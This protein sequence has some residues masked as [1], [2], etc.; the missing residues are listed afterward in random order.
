MQVI[1][2]GTTGVLGFETLQVLDRVTGLDAIG[3][4]RRGPLGNDRLT[5]L[6]RP[7]LLDADWA[8][9]IDRGAAII[10]F[11]GL[12]SPR[13]P[14]HDLDDLWQ[15]TIRPQVSFVTRLLDAGWLGHFVYISSGGAIYGDAPEL[16]ISE[17]HQTAPKTHYALQKLTVEAQ[18]S[19]LALR[20]GFPLTI[21]RLSNPFGAQ[22][23]TGGRGVVSMLIEAARSGKP[24]T[25][26]NG[27]K[28]KRDFLHVD[29]MVEGIHAILRRKRSEAI[30]IVHLGSGVGTSILELISEIEH[31]TGRQIRTVDVHAPSVVGDIVLDV[32]RAK[33][34]FRW[35]PKIPLSEGLARTIARYPA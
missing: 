23:Q 30:D 13:E 35:A 12:S 2:T 25:I 9:E 14:F 11:A 32:S 16:P 4:S 26:Q 21:L 27:G 17:T 15:Q 10:H 33:E 34:L 20:H 6:T 5:N 18:L 29:D 24:F 19:H 22:L 31:Q 7:N 1:V 8:R 3:V 28:A